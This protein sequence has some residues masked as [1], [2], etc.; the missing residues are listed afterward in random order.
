MGGKRRARE[1]LKGSESR[2]EI[3]RETKRVIERERKEESEKRER[4]G[5]MQGQPTE[6]E[7]G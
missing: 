3:E 1:F 7:R 5:E 6:R 2:K 4:D